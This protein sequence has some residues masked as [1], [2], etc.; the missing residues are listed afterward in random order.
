MNTIGKIS[1]CEI[2]LGY[3][4][5]MKSEGEIYNRYKYQI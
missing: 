1:G 3:I 4:F 2:I 5:R